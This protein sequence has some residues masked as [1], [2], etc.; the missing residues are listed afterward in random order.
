MQIERQSGGMVNSNDNVVF[1]SILNSAGN[2]T[3]N[4]ATGVMTFLTAGRYVLSW[5][6]ATQSS[7]SVQ[8]VVFA[9]VTSAGEV[10]KGNSPTKTGEVSGI[11]IIEVVTPPLTVS[12]I[13]ASGDKVNFASIVP[14]KAMLL[15]NQTPIGLSYVQLFDRNYT[16]ELTASGPLNLSNVGINPIYTEG[17]YTLSTTTVTNDTLNLPGS[18]LYYLGISIRASFLLPIV[19]PAFG[20]TYQILFNV[21]NEADANIVNLNYNGIIPN[22][23]NAVLDTQLSTQV[24]YRTNSP[25]PSIKVLLSNFDFSLAFENML[26]VFDIIVIVQKW[27]PN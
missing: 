16:N 24:L 13:N 14:V 15:V 26:S 11:G 27:E 12:L 25:S 22:D 3:Y 7:A 6:A 18:G 2:I 8:G 21:I 4:T 17:G 5:W 19:P 10:L 9:L 20:S 23:P 1:E